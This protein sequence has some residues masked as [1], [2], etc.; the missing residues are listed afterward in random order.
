MSRL[1]RRPRLLCAY[2]SYTGNT[3][4]AVQFLCTA[5][6]AT[7]EVDVVEIVPRHKRS[8]LHWLA[9]S[10]VPGSEVEIEN[11]R[12][13][14]SEYHGVVLGFPKWTFSC[15]PV[16]K[17]ISKLASLQVPVLFLLMTCGG[18]DEKRFMRSLI[19]RLQGIGCEVAD[20]LTIK[21]EWIHEG[22]HTILVEPFAKRIEER[23]KLR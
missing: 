23:L 4:R 1:G 21:R 7:F 18:F 17:F 11:Q 9:Y 3:R 10:F 5:L 2:F 14:L 13:E 16:N 22:T 20:S 12:M 8:Y 6:R 15:P 19:C